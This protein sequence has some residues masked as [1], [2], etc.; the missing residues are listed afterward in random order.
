MRLIDIKQCIN[1][2]FDNLDFKVSEIGGG[3]SKIY[4]VQKF[5][6]VLL[7]LSKAGFVRRED[8]KF[9][10]DIVNAVNTDSLTYPSSNYIGDYMKKN[11]FE[12]YINIALSNGAD[13]AE[14]YYEESIGNFYQLI[15]SKLDTINTNIKKG[16]GI[17]IRKGENIS[18]RRPWPTT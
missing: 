8:F 13:F 4:G 7:Q 9:Y 10:D 2:A 11:E 14:I 3:N 18:R 12:E 6:I 15:D 17:R 1:I 16:I 5:R